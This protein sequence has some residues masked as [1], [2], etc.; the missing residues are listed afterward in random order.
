MGLHGNGYAA[1]L[2]S[3]PVTMYDRPSAT[4]QYPTSRR[5][6]RKSRN[7]MIKWDPNW[8]DERARRGS[9]T[10]EGSAPSS[11]GGFG[12]GLAGAPAKRSK[13]IIKLWKKSI[14][15]VIFALALSSGQVRHDAILAA[16][17][18]LRTSLQASGAIPSEIGSRSPGSLWAGFAKKAGLNFNVNPR[19]MKMGGMATLVLRLVEKT[20]EGANVQA[21]SLGEKRALWLQVK[22]HRGSGGLLSGTVLRLSDA[23]VAGALKQPP[24]D[25]ATVYIERAGDTEAQKALS[26]RLTKAAE[27][28]ERQRTPSQSTSPQMA[29]TPQRL[30]S[31]GTSPLP[32]VNIH[33]LTDGTGGIAVAARD[34]MYRETG[35]DEYYTADALQTRH[36]LSTS[37]RL[38]ATIQNLWKVCLIEEAGRVEFRQGVKDG[39]IG[40]HTYVHLASLMARSLVDPPDDD[41]TAVALAQEDWEADCKGQE[42]MSWSIFYEGMF[43]LCDIWVDSLSE[44]DY[45]AFFK[46]LMV[47]VCEEDMLGL[48]ALNN[49]E[50][51]SSGLGDAVAAQMKLS[52]DLSTSDEEKSKGGGESKSKGGGAS[53]SKGGSKGSSGGDGAGSSKGGGRGKAGRGTDGNDAKGYRD[54][55]FDGA[56]DGAGYARHSASAEG[57]AGR[58]ET[59]TGN[60]GS[61]SAG[62]GGAVKGR[63]GRGV[64]EG[65]NAKYSVTAESR[66]MQDLQRRAGAMRHMKELASNGRSYT[67]VLSTP[68]DTPMSIRAEFDVKLAVDPYYESA[69]ASVAEASQYAHPPRPF[70]AKN[71][72]TRIPARMTKETQRVRHSLGIDQST[73]RTRKSTVFSMKGMVKGTAHHADSDA[74]ILNGERATKNGDGATPSVTL[75]LTAA[76]DDVLRG[77]VNLPR[78]PHLSPRKVH[79]TT[80]SSG[81][82]QGAGIAPSGA[83]PIPDRIMYHMHVQDRRMARDEARLQAFG[84]PQPLRR[85]LFVS[86]L[87]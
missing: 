78:L 24:P 64:T 49:V 42:R 30:A 38:I 10:A 52:V 18:S 31:P 5:L 14:R 26:S 46:V 43:D 82:S 41:V 86:L 21:L 33:N 19:T 79:H 32:A 29:L 73:G 53:K 65:L 60:T 28:E 74:L 83:L 70:Q 22:V 77:L 87:A 61:A 54:G 9:R 12:T 67:R 66:F 27:K 72:S 16:R 6:R 56:S 4:S 11:A 75:P 25:S 71:P 59:A 57:S 36:N 76:C 68:G 15:K 44:D 1:V 55:R 23:L 13:A 17:V 51:V 84:P 7:S 62:R 81:T 48:R 80:S 34:A 39:A 40:Q 45:V 20:K 58:E 8:L 69:L 3:P 50:C 35:N 63:S 2:Q 85:E 47:N 37:Q